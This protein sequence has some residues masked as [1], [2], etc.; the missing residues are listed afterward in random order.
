MLRDA[1]VR[2]LLATGFLAAAP[3]LPAHAAEPSISLYC[4]RGVTDYPDA[5]LT[6]STRGSHLVKVVFVGYRPSRARAD[7]SLRDCLSTA[8]KFDGSRDIVAS[9]WYRDRAL[10]SPP[11]PLRPD[12][13]AASLVYQAARH[14]VVVQRRETRP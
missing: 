10:R 9:L 11:E 5:E 8:I 12:G 7:W 4:A 6:L 2:L 13:A 14:A 1:A 3:Q